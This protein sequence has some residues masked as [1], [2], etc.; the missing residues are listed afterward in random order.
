MKPFLDHSAEHMD[1]CGDSPHSIWPTTSRRRHPED[2][3]DDYIFL[4]SDRLE[5]Q[6]QGVPEM[7]P[8]IYYCSLCKHRSPTAR[9]LS[10]HLSRSH[11]IK[12]K[13]A[14]YYAGRTSS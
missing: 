6:E 14:D 10:V 3:W 12:S 7:P 1:E 4:Y 13:R 5:L 2:E 8:E 9:G 11:D